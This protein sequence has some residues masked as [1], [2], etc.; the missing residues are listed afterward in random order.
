MGRTPLRDEQ[1]VLWVRAT[2]ILQPCQKDLHPSV[3]S[4]LAYHR[5]L[6]SLVI[7]NYNVVDACAAYAE[8]PSILPKSRPMLYSAVLNL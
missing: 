7:Q 6:L 3:S 5:L 4:F 2:M 1:Q 8:V